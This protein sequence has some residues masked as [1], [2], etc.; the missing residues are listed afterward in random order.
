MSNGTRF[1]LENPLFDRYLSGLQAHWKPGLPEYSK[2]GDKDEL[3]KYTTIDNFPV[4]NSF[5]T[6]ANTLMNRWFYAFSIN[7]S[8]KTNSTLFGKACFFYARS[9]QQVENYYDLNIQDDQYYLVKHEVSCLAASTYPN[10]VVES[11]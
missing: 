7:S 9:S 3:K 2:L 10:P 6:T 4:G 5:Y 11:K 1:S 8:I